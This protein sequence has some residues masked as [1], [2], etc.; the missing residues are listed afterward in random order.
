MVLLILQ[1]IVGLVAIIKGADWLTDGAAQIARRFG[2]PSIVVG[3][4]IVA[5]GSSAPELVVSV[6]AALQSNADMAV[7]FLITFAADFLENK[8]FLAFEVFQHGSLNS[9]TLDIGFANG[10]IAIIVFE[11][12]G[13]E[14]NLAT[15]LVLEAVYEDLLI[16]GYLELLACDFYYCVHF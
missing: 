5:I 4:T 12:H 9:S 11:H 6:V 10:Y 2:I 3:L 7:H 15:F 1:F 13:V 8:N 14:R 16:L